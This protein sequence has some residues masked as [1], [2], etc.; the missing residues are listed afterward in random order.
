MRFLP[1]ALKSRNYQLFFSGQGLSLVGNWI[2]QTAMIWLVYQLTDSALWLGVVGFTSQIPSFVLA[3]IGGIVVDRVHR[4]RLLIG[5]QFLSMMQSIALTILAL[6]NVIDVWHIIALSLFQGLINAFDAPAR[7]AFVPEMIEKKEDLASAI[8]LNS[9]LFS[10]ARLL[11]PGIAGLLIAT[12]GTGV[13]FL[14]DSISYFAVIC[15]LLAMKIK[16]QRIALLTTKPWQRLKEGFTYAF[17]FPPICNILLFL[18]YSSF[19]GISTTTLIPIFATKILQG[20]S[21]TLG[22]L[23][24]ASGIGALSGG[25]YLASRRSVVGLG[26]VIAYAPAILGVAMIFF[27]LSRVLALSLILIFLSGAAGVLQLASS[28]TVIQTIVEDDKRG[29]VMSLYTMAVLGIA[30]LGSLVAGTLANKI[31]APT[32]VFIAGICCIFGS[33]I[34]AQQ[35]PILRTLVRPIYMNK[36]IITKVY[37]SK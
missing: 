20:G 25:I 22:F 14:I 11:G 30:P 34:F 16:P 8:A 28:N 23:M 12:V 17:G 13:C 4:H 7:Q 9:S 18:A 26:K 35:L 29:R 36:G 24:A 37:S 27:S 6:T 19:M 33:L 1:P 5:T 32:T 15:A 21:Q 2:T 10:T 31:G 3:P